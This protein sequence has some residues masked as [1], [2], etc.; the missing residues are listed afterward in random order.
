MQ[1]RQ[2]AQLV[3]RKYAAEL[4]DRVA[5]APEYMTEI[6]LAANSFRRAFSARTAAG[7]F[8]LPTPSRTRTT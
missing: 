1:T 7:R 3:S 8:S 6:G 2:F 4:R 5:T